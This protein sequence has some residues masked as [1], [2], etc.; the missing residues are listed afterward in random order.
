MPPAPPVPPGHA[1]P[2]AGAAK[3]EAVE[4]IKYGWAAFKKSPAT[5]LVP[6]L[7]VILAVVVI[8]VIVQLILTKAFLGTGDCTLDQALNNDCGPSFLTSLFVAA[9]G[10]GIGTFISQVLLAGLIKSSLNVVDGQ[11][12]LDLGG[13]LSWASKPA[14]ITTA[15]LLAALSFVG[16][17]FFYLPA[18]IISFLTAFTMYFV[19]DRNLSGVEAIKASVTFVTSRLGETLVFMLLGGLTVIAGVIACFVGVFVAIPVVLVAA[20]YTYRVLHDQPVAPAA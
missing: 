20:A 16:T 2:P 12:A 5:L 10:A 7:V 3:Y 1:A 18:I 17:L 19:V 4:A 14:V 8:Q 15:A 11:P 13:V 9:V 6:A